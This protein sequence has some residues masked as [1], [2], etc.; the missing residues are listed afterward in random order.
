MAVKLSLNLLTLWL[1]FKL[2]F[3]YFYGI[4]YLVQTIK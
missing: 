1:I 2:L 3:T 4:V